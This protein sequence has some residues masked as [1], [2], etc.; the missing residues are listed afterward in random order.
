[1]YKIIYDQP[2]RLRV[3]MGKHAFTKEQ[4][5]GIEQLA[6]PFSDVWEIETNPITGGILIHYEPH[7]RSTVLS[8]L[9]DLNPQVIAEAKPTDVTVSREMDQRFRGI[10]VKLGLVYLAKRLLLPIPIRKGL[11]LIKAIPY[12]KQGVMSLL[13]GAL[14]VSVLDASAL[15][16]CLVTKD[17]DTASTTMTLLE[18]SG[19]LED[20]TFKKAKQSLSQSLKLNIDQVWQV[21][22]DLLTETPTS[23]IDINDV[24]RV[25]SGSTIPLDGH[26][27]GGE[28]LVNES[29]MTGESHSLLRRSGNRVYAGTVIEEGSLD[30]C[31]T[32]RYDETRIH[33]IITRIE[34]NESLKAQ[35][36]TKAERLAQTVVPLSFLLVGVTWLFTRNLKRAVSVLMVDFSCAFK[37]TTPIAII[38]AMNEA[39]QKSMLVKGGKFLEGVALADTIVFDKTGTLTESK[40]KVEKVIPLGVLSREEVLKISACLE[41]HFPHSVAKAVVAAAEEEG[42]SHREEHDKPEYIVA[43][44]IASTLYDQKVCIGSWHFIVEDEGVVPTA[45]QQV[46]IDAHKVGY[47]SI[48]LALGD[49]L[50]GMICIK[51]TLR[52]EAAGVIEKLKTLGIKRVV[53]ITGDS[54]PVAASVAETLGIE[55]YW[56]NVLPEAK[57]DLIKE[58]QASGYTVIMVGDGINDSPALSSADVSVAMKAGSDIAKEVADITL[59]KD[60]L[61]GLIELKELSQRLVKQINRN[62]TTII[63]FNTGLILLGAI[64]VIQPATSALLHNGSTLVLCTMNTK[65]R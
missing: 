35:M 20:Y 55:D 34:T 3:R 48:Y 46:L 50:E 65:I 28:A 41:E 39:A 32:A 51:D 60:D 37:L 49:Q 57:A 53:M 47:T 45:D 8:F 15:L 10:L 7:A 30:I 13:S 23:Q 5:Y 2:G 56:A 33:H 58:L 63:G 9:N 16:V 27:I 42:I 1:M 64:G 59:M 12:L 38:S 26:V 40:P 14:N 62:Y 25:A 31:V 24:I 52:T 19:H 36:Q 61:T 43:H 18:L 44:G 22:G 6:K 29:A 4:G 54:E 17:A 11:T 21:A